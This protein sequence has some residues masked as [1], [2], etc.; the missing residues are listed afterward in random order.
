LE[1]LNGGYPSFITQPK[2]SPGQAFF[3]MRGKKFGDYDMS[4]NNMMNEKRA[5]AGFVGMRG[6]KSNL[7]MFDE[8]EIDD[9]QVFDYNYHDKRTPSGF[10]GVRGKKMYDFMYR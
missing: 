3:G 7:D 10:L 6:K 5:P 4:F 8:N 1:E 9:P 2:R